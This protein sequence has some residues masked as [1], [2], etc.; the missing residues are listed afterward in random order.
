VTI[1]ATDTE[2]VV[3][4]ADGSAKVVTRTND[5]PVWWTKAHR[6]RKVEHV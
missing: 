4:F 3:D 6:P 1:D 2:L 5:H